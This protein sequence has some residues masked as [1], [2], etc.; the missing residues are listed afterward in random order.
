MLTREKSMDKG[1]VIPVLLFLCVTF[2]VTYVIKLLVDARVRIKMLQ[3]SESKELIESVI[4]GDDHRGRMSSL[5]W[6]LLLLLGGLGFAIIQWAGWTDITP[7]ALA[8]LLC[9]FGLSNLI[10]FFAAR[11]ITP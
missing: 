9:A 5:R 3:A 7:G 2:G 11:R 6:G 10:Y 8:V 4:R 1:T